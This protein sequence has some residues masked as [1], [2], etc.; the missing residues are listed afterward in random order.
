MTL[1]GVVGATGAVGAAVARA[2]ATAGSAVVRLG[3]RRPDALRPLLAE[4]GERAEAVGVD[5]DEPDSLERFCAGCRVVV[6]G[7]GPLAA[8]RVAVAA[9]AWRAGGDYVDPGGGEALPRELDRIDRPGARAAVVAAGAMPGLTGLVPRWLAAQ[10][11]DRPHSLTAYVSTM[12]RMTPA[13]AAEFLLGLGGDGEAGASWRAGVRVSHDLEPMPRVELPFFAGQVAAFPHLSVETERLARALRLAEVRWY[14]VFDP[15]GQVLPALSRL[16]EQLRQGGVVTG[17]AA[18]L[19]RAA[20]IDMLG[21]EP[22]QQFVF[23][24]SGWT[25]GEL[26]HRV[27][28]LRSSS[29]YE[30]TAAVTSMAIAALLRGDVPAGVHAAAEVLDPALVAGLSGEQGVV[31]WHLLDGPLQEYA[32]I[33]QGAL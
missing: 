2:V 15:D 1:I 31:G 33:D 4:L 8:S 9:M 20:E 21:R 26:A 12:D 13:S 14:H 19:S 16:Q 17:L 27:A 30:L 11:F 32:E 22:V 18:T 5:A 25:G 28:L 10:G 29:T 3:A 7:V 6:N 24:L 23:Q